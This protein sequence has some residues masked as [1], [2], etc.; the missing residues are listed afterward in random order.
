MAF[1]RR[2]PP[3]RRLLRR[4]VRADRRWREDGDD[5]AGRAG[6]LT[7]SSTG[8]RFGFTS[9][10][11]RRSRT[12]SERLRPLGRVLADVDVCD[13]P[14]DSDLP[15]DR[16]GGCPDA[17]PRRSRQRDLE[18]LWRRPLHG[19]EGFALVPSAMMLA[20]GRWP[21]ACCPGCPGFAVPVGDVAVARYRNTALWLPPAAFCCCTVEHGF[22]ARFCERIKGVAAQSRRGC[23][24]SGRRPR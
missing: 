22:G 24:M 12:R 19:R 14:Q 20:N 18:A 2:P 6:V 4:P 7:R 11:F 9:S 16:P 13:P 5:C 23:W 8:S 1:G 21:G 3:G 10:W 17:G 15:S